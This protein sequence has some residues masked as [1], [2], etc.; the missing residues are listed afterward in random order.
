MKEACSCLAWWLHE[1]GLV[2]NPLGIDPCLLRLD[3][4]LC[5]L[6]IIQVE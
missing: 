4:H 5:S 3:F 1:H 2:I 6:K